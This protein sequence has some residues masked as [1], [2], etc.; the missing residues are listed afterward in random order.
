MI[1]FS[2]F[3]CHKLGFYAKFL[4]FLGFLGMINCLDL[5]K[6]SKKERNFGKKEKKTQDL[7]K[8]L[9]VI[10]NHPKSWQK[11]PRCQELVIFC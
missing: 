10:Q 5:G 6:K 11:K 2:D 1:F 7:G 3:Q 9:K 4:N 8:K